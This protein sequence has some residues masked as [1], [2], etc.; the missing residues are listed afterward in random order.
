MSLGKVTLES[1]ALEALIDGDRD[2]AIEL[3]EQL[4][5]EEAMRVRYAAQGLTA[6]LG[7]VI[8]RPMRQRHLKA[9]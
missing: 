1:L 4:T 2:L 8:D 5:P 6:L 9:V 3:V 7:Y